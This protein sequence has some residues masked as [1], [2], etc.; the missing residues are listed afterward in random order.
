VLSYYVSLCSEFPCC[1]VHSDFC[2]KHNVRFVFTCSF[3]EGPM[4]Y[5][6]YLCLFVHSGVQHKWYCVFALFSSSCVP[7]VAS[8]S[9]FF[10]VLCTICCQFLC[11]F[12]RLVYHMLPVS[13]D[14]P[15]VIAPSVFC[16][17][18]LTMD[19]FFGISW[20]VGLVYGV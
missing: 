11:V 15:F 19:Y 18:Y 4:S 1:N 12:L 7:Y 14:C 13:L 17:I 6:R 10:F 9:V 8:F 5:L 20:W 16:N 3:V 2:I